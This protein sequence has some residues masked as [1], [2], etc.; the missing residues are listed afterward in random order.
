MSANATGPARAQPRRRLFAALLTVLVMAVVGAG[1]AGAFWVGRHASERMNKDLATITMVS[2]S[3]LSLYDVLAADSVQSVEDPAFA[4]IYGVPPGDP[5]A[6]AKRLRAVVYSPAAQ[7]APFVGHVARPVKG[8]DLTINGFGFRDTRRSYSDKPPG[9]VRVF[10]TGGSTAWGSGAPSQRQTISHLLEDMLNARAAG[11]MRYEV[12]NAAFP[13]WSTTQEKILIQQVIADLRPDVVIMVSGNNDVHW[14]LQ[15]EDIRWFFSYADRNFVTM[16]NGLYHGIG[17]LEWM[18]PVA[19]EAPPRPCAELGP[20][21]SRNAQEAA[22]ALARLPAR[23][24]FA[25]QPNL[26]TT[27]KPLT[28]REQRLVKADGR[29]YWAECYRSM[30]AHLGRLAAGNFQFL[31]LSRMFGEVDGGTELFIDNYHFAE[32]GNKLVAEA[33]ARRIDWAAIA[34][35]SR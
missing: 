1:M 12:I 33:L 4:A 16:V 2:G 20:L 26:M 29:A 35:A 8:G 11:G 14:S 5:Q 28:P 18:T 19:R 15:G 3:P 7:P 25:L 9:T 24:V 6:L 30:I 22:F 17:Q 31:D 13:A 23:L 27:A 21:S 32:L 34:P 10:I